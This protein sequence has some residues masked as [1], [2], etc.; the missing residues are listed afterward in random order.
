[1]FNKTIYTIME[2]KSD[3]PI[4]LHFIGWVY[5]W[6]AIMHFVLAALN[7]KILARL[8]IFPSSSADKYTG[9]A[10]NFLRYVTLFSCDTFGFYVSWVCYLLAPTCAL[11]NPKREGLPSIW[12]ASNHSTIWAGLD[13]RGRSVCRDYSRPCNSRYCAPLNDLVTN[14][15]VPSFSMPVLP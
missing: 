6:S 5:L 15:L 4:Y 10:C 1:M 2:G 12:R 14:N 13:N 11:L 7:G 3:S 9:A 8:E